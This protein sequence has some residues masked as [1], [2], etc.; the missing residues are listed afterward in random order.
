[1]MDQ[2]FSNILVFLLLRWLVFVYNLLKFPRLKPMPTPENPKVSILIP[3]RNEAENLKR[4][5]PSVLRQ[6][7][8][9]V[10]VLDDLSEDETAQVAQEIGK[11]YPGFRLIRGKPPPQGWV[12]KNWACWQ[13]AQEARGEIL[14]FTDADVF[15]EEGALGG[16]I[17][18]LEGKD[19][20][21]ALTRQ[22]GDTAGMLV[23]LM[24][25]L[26]SFLPHP[27]LE[28]LGFANGQVL[29]FRRDAYWSIG[30][31]QA[32]KNEVLEDI[33]IGRRVK[34]YGLRYRLYLG[35]DLFRVR[36]YRNYLETIQ[37]LG[38]NFLDIHMKNPA[39]LLGSAYYHLS[40]YTVPWLFGRWDLG[41]LGILERAFVQIALKDRLLPAF[42]T[43]IVPILFLPIY[44]RALLPGK[45]W[46]GRPV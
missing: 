41:L 2:F 45:T 33:N 28:A 42:F 16:L 39:I 10:L 13:L 1:M 46:K 32:V 4:N 37:G 26:F 7:A 36:M 9:E 43:P 40:I 35:L 38:K 18:A 25:G 27:A 30:G 15:W 17:S 29:A 22:E 21:S 23:F 19:V 8:F 5:L 3:A 12:G 24:N 44:I 14:V 20:I 31:H 11:G 34:K 6:G